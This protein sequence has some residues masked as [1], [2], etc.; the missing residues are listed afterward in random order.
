MIK[1][2]NAV[3]LLIYGAAYANAVTLK[4]DSYSAEQALSQL[5]EQA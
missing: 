5:D 2:T 1:M 3:A 4:R